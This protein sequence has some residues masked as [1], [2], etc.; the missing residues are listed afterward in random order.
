MGIAQDISRTRNL[1][2]VLSM[3]YLL[4]GNFVY[5]QGTTYNYFYRVYFKDKGNYNV[6]SFKAT[7][8]LSEKAISRRQ[9]AGIPDLDLSDLPVNTTYINQIISKGFCLHCTSKWLNTALFKTQN[10]SDISIILNFPFI[11]DVK[12]VKKPVGKSNY[13]NKLDFIEEQADIPFDRPITM[14]N[15]FPLHYSGYDGTGILIAVLDGGFYKADLISSLDELRERNGI[16]GTYNVIDKNEFVYDFHN[17]GTAVL[18]VLAGRISGM[19]EGTAPGADFWLLRTEDVST[20]FPVE[21]DFW[22]AGAEFADSVGADIISSSLGYYNFD[23]PAMNYKFSEMDG[24]TTFV[25][26]AADMAASKGILVVCSAGNERI[27][28]WKRI[29]APSD[30]D[31]VIA[32]GAVDGQYNISTFSSA[33][34]SADRRIKPDNVAQ[35]VSVPV[36]TDENSVGRASGT[37]FSCPVL[38]GMCAC[39]MQAVPKALNTDIIYNLHICAD[40]Y[41]SPD[42]LYGYGIPD[43]VQVVTRLQEN[44][45]TIPDNETITGPNPFSGDIEIT[46]K[47][48]PDLLTLEIYSASGDVIIK[49]NYKEYI[50]R[51][52]KISDLQNS[53]QGVYFIRLITANGTFTHKVIKINN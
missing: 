21:E 33:G 14:L 47:H 40:R 48:I 1:I 23:D 3:T 31:S 7:D 44:L 49:R 38:S 34:P 18:S 22:A 10:Q 13:T 24:N 19:I 25:T 15:G 30:G 20:E 46:F 17:H 42:S 45:V 2:L 41:N 5:G 4:S 39:V 50:G 6:N 26:R 37:S 53:Q 27:T 29:I 32:A 9:K 28:A 52:L 12:I 11:R 35:G 16:K 36:Q 43:M 51:T 8:L